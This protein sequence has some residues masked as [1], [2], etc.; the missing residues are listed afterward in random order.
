MKKLTKKQK[1]DIL[2]KIGVEGLDYYL[3]DYQSPESVAGTELEAPWQEYLRIRN[4]ILNVL[5][6]NER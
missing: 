4:K 5:G 2:D 1:S 3:T 6:F